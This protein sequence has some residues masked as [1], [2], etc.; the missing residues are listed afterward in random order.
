MHVQ[1]SI[2]SLSRLTLC[3]F[4]FN[5]QSPSVM[6]SVPELSFISDSFSEPSDFKN[7]NETQQPPTPSQPTAE[8]THKRQTEAG[9][10]EWSTWQLQSVAF[11]TAKASRDFQQPTSGPRGSGGTK[12]GDGEAE[13]QAKQTWTTTD[14]E[15][16]RD[17]SL[18]R[19]EFF[20]Q[21]EWTVHFTTRTEDHPW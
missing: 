18:K 10:A 14:I 4:A 21:P 12:S 17:A 7:I 13:S 1:L 9:S 6:P 5:L 2:S 11:K 3:M 15:W 16:S 20:L 19:N 8:Q